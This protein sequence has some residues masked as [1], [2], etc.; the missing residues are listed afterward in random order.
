MPASPGD[1]RTFKAPPPQAS[2]ARPPVV[3]A[4][5][6]RPAAADG[7][8]T[9]KAPP[10]QPQASAAPPPVVPAVAPQ[11]GP[12]AP[13][14][15]H[16]VASAADASTASAPVATAAP[17]APPPTSLAQPPQAVL[18]QAQVAQQAMPLVAAQPLASAVAAPQ[19]SASAASASAFPPAASAGASAPILPAAV[20]PPGKEWK[21]TSAHWTYTDRAGWM[22]HS[23]SWALVDV[24]ANWTGKPGASEGT[25][26]VIQL[27][28]DKKFNEALAMIAD[29]PRCA[30]AFAVYPSPVAGNNL[31]HVLSQRSPKEFGARKYEDCW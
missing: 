19:P 22:Q 28:L 7:A 13:A 2:A 15:A 4:A 12:V 1:A 5:Q 10:P 26:E 24:Y 9:F 11:G 8:R 27:L 23:Q 18:A 16:P 14:V 25:P 31:I 29:D 21:F 3:P 6:V 17:D 20:A 30:L